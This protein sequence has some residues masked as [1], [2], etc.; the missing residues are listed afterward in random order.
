[1]FR[2]HFKTAWRNL[3]KRKVFTF[4]NLLGLAIGMAVCLLLALYIQ[5]ELGYDSFQEKGSQIYRLAVERIYPGRTA[6]EGEIPQSIG[7]A[8]KLEFPEVLESVRIIRAGKTV[9]VGNKIFEDEKIMGVDSNFFRVFTANLIQGSKYD[10]LQ[11]PNTAVINESTAKRFFGSAQN[12]INK[13]ILINGIHDCLIDGVCKDWPA[14]S[15]FQFTILVSNTSFNL[16]EPDY[17]DFSTYTY[18]LLNK[19]AS[20]EALEAKLP[21]IVTKYVAPTIEKGFGESFEDFTKEGNGYKY[22][23]QPIQKIH[24]HSNLQ[25]ELSPTTSIDIIYLAAAI[26]LFILFLACINFINLSTA[27]SV[28]RAR[29]IGIRKTFG[30]NKKFIIWQFLSES[31]LFSLISVVL[32]ALLARLFLPL[33]NN[34]AG[35]ELSFAYF[36]NPIRVMLIPGFAVLIGIVAGLYPAL[37]LSSFRPIAVLKGRFKSS[38]G[39]VALRN[40]LVIFQ[41]AISVILI[42]CTI[43]INSQMQFMLG[44]KLGFTKD[45]IIAIDGTYR[46]QNNRQAFINEVSKI[47]GVEDWSF[48]N[49][50]PEGQPYPSCA[51]QSIDTKVSRTERTAFVDERYQS[52]LNLQL[53]AG[54]FF[55]KD[56]TTDSLGLVLNEEAVKDF[57]L[58]HPIGSR[59]T[60]TELFFNPPDGKSQTV[61]TVIGVVKDFY[62]ES[63]HQKIAPLVLANANKFGAGIAAI[64]I[65]GQDLSSAIPAIEKT[66]KQ[67]D[68]KDSFKYSFLDDIIAEQYKAEETAQKIFTAFSLLAILIACIGLFGLVTYSTFQR[69]KEISIRK[70]LGASAGNIIFILSKDFIKLVTISAPIAFPV[71]WWATH[72]WL[73]NFAYRVNINWW[74]FA[75]ALLLTIIIA[76]I[77]VS[78][79]A[80]KAAIAN[81]VKSLRTE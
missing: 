24:L 75:V 28:E 49:D 19:N 3:K 34:I 63:L 39:G 1:M 23:L 4:I 26:S 9:N 20:P 30:S 70:V 55:S 2:N 53:T 52:L 22:F 74:V 10:A 31:I 32:G 27:I 80:I 69:T 72:T 79:Q 71:A 25:D 50:L 15:H 68:P 12:A 11:K 62:F 42:I 33:L 56:F 16:N 14:K 48:C 44:N 37:V 40:G 43:V 5:S 65:K 59:I 73:Q 47:N 18:L 35:S 29:E 81:P 46:L 21:L 77:T 54:R 57:G 51:M 60:S 41:F 7:Q 58:I 17:Y 8:V 6:Y 66:W 78:F 76:F 45:N 67:F 64:R 36:F 13:H 38:K 61:Y